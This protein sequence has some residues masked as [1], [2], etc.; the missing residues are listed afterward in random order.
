MVDL[1][2][3][4]RQPESMNVSLAKASLISFIK[5]IH[6]PFKRHTTHV[7]DDKKAASMQVTDNEL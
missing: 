1:M 7:H 3:C 4:S 5:R 2:V 6:G